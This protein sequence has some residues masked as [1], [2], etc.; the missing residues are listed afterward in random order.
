LCTDSLVYTSDEGGNSVGDS[1]KQRRNIGAV[2]CIDIIIK[3]SKVSVEARACRL[4]IS[5]TQGL[6]CFRLTTHSEGENTSVL[7]RVKVS[8]RISLTAPAG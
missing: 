6:S 4:M 5:E 2:A 1:G 7:C 8:P 3:V